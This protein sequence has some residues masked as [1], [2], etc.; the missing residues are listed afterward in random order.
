M[1][2][3]SIFF[4]FPVVP[5]PKLIS[6]RHQRAADN[7][8]S[9][10]N[11]SGVV[12]KVASNVGSPTKVAKDLVAGNPKAKEAKVWAKDCCPKV[13]WEGTTPRPILTGEGYAMTINSEDV[14][15]RPTEQN[16]RRDGIYAAGR[17]VLRRAQNANTTRKSMA[18]SDGLPASMILLTLVRIFCG[19]ARVTASLKQLGLVNSFGTDHVKHRQAS[20][21]VVLADLTARQG[22]DLLFQWLSNRFVVGVYIAP[23]CGSSSRARAIRLKR[24]HVGKEP[25]PLRSNRFPNGI[26]GLQFVDRIKICKANKLYH[27]TS[28]LIA[29]AHDVGALFCIEN[30]QFSHFWDTSF[31]RDVWHLLQFSVFHSCQYGGSRLKRTMLAFNAIEFQAS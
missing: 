10:R 18:T 11:S 2:W 9:N 1:K 31:I 22:V 3:D 26:P 21:Q 19:T 30:P 7:L 27:L 6:P 28:R 13:C 23:P 4:H 17:I 25:R 8:H 24:K 5:L 16:A 29:W 20:A 15:W 12:E 14:L